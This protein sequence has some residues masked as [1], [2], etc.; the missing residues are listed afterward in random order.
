[1]QSRLLSLRLI[2][3]LARIAFLLHRRWMPYAKW[4]EKTFRALPVA[5]LLIA[6]LSMAT[7]GDWRVR[8]RGLGAAT[9]ELLRLQRELGFTT[10]DTGIVAF[11]DRPYLTI[12]PEVPQALLAP[13]ADPEL[14]ALPPGIG[15]IEQWVDNTDVLAHPERRRAIIATYR[16]W[17]AR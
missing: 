15:S 6:P 5:D 3:D 10:T 8:E 9:R 1:C 11:W 12:A 14:T 17:L 2:E 7:D 13:I 16:A 4:F